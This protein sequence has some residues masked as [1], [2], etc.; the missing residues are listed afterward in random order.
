MKSLF[1][2]ALFISNLGFAAT[3]N[4]QNGDLYQ[5]KE[6]VNDQPTGKICYLYVDY[7]EANPVGKYCHNLT[8]RPVFSTDRATQPQDPIV[9]QSRVTNYHRPEY[10]QIKTC[11]MN[12]DGKTSGND[13]YGDQDAN[14]YNELFA[15]EGQYDGSQFDFFV[16]LSAQTKLPIRTRLHKLNW[17]SETDYD[18]VDLI[19]L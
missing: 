2:A 10:P 12:L 16:T 3:I 1:I 4:S 13:I 7:V 19:K 15:W 18:C 17:H 5:G 6:I 11:A 9:V 14:L 8:T